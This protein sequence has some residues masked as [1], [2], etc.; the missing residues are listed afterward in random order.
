MTT[1]ANNKT[2]PC[3]VAYLV[4]GENAYAKLSKED[5]EKI[6]NGRRG[7]CIMTKGEYLYGQHH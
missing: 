6:L 5:F 4:E 2:Q 1:L 7:A 3:G